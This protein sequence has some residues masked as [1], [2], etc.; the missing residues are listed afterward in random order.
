M[1]IAVVLESP[2][3]VG[4]GY[5]QA[6][7]AIQQLRRVCAN[8]HV[9]E[10]YT[11]RAENV[12]ELARLGLPAVHRP[13]SVVDRLLDIIAFNPLW[14]RLQH[15]RTVSGPFETALRRAGVDL[16]Y[17]LTP[18]ST[19]ACLT[20][21][22][23]ITTVFDLAHRDHPE[24]P[25]VGA[26]AEFHARE[27]HL[28]HNLARAVV[29]VTA[30]PTLSDSLAARYGVDTTRMLAMPFAVSDLID[31]DTSADTATALATYG[32]EQGYFFYPA[33]FWAHKNH[34]RILEAMLHLRA[35]GIERD[36]VFAGGDQGNRAHVESFAKANALSARTHFLGFVP[37]DHLRGLYDGCCTLVMPT[38]FGPTNLPP[39]EAWHVGR[40]VVY[41]SHLHNDTGDAAIYAPPDNADALADAMEQSLDPAC[42]ARLVAAGRERLRGL[43]ARREAAE[44]DLASR[45]DAFAVKRSC[46]R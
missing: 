32:L 10:V 26:A 25:E 30:S 12:G 19:P 7:N 35:R 17:F 21:M 40:P 23:F 6:L 1:K 16:V 27:R 11:T 42:R 13:I 45:L 43:T 34:I 20:R 33:Q 22:G 28:R 4:G 41:S 46:W 8:R 18:S 29:V 38:Y 14:Q 2:V 24:F 39:L 15:R 44:A 5:S 31:G 37:T 36:V 3:H 9:I